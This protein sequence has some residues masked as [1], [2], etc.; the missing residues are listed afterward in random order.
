[1]NSQPVIVIVSLLCVATSGAIL[2]NL[3]VFMMIGE[4]NRKKAEEDLISY[5]GVTQWKMTRIFRNYRALYPNGKLHI[6]FGMAVGVMVICLVSLA[7]IGMFP[8]HDARLPG[9]R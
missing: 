6:Y 1:M 5:F 9:R 3:L 8:S 4:I 7:L 2:A